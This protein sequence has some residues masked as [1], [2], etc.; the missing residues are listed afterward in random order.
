MRFPC[1]KPRIFYGWYVLAASFVILFLNAGSRAAIGLMVKPMEA[2]LHWTRGSIS[3]VIFLNLAV[4]AVSVIVT[5]RLYDRYGPK[6]IIAASTMLFAAGHALMASMDSLWEFYLYYGILNASGLAGTTVAL[7]GSVVGH[8]FEKHR[9]LAVSLAF[10][11]TCFGQ[12]FLVPLFSHAVTVTGWRVTNLWIAGL[13]L[14][15]NLALTLGVIRGTPQALGLQPYGA[16]GQESPAV[17]TRPHRATPSLA[18]APRDL[19]LG[20]AMRSRSLWLFTIAMFA[21]GSA[22][23]LVNTHL[24]PMVTDYGLSD[25]V[26]ANMLAWLGL[27]SLAGM[28]VAGPVAD[29]IGNKLPI[30]TTFALRIGLFVMVMLVK[31]PVAFWIFS[32]GF[33][34]TIMVTAPLTLTL[35]GDLYGVTH[36]GFISGF[37]VTIHTVGGGLGVFLAGVIFDGTGDYNVAFL[38][39]AGLAF[40][41]MA[42]SLFIREER[43]SVPGRSAEGAAGL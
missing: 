29:A 38:L 22:D 12:F 15:V 10:A 13:A 32:L 30:V 5:G 11:G 39:S 3:S 42:C 16:R 23:F 20:E 43:H 18:A 33:G 26:A 9:G 34:F 25:A 24:V 7:F 14:V 1:R 4:Y 40:V 2:D 31:G 8:W 21:C 37:I 6:W 41:A 27:L 17:G 35:V 28:L 19:T 36:I